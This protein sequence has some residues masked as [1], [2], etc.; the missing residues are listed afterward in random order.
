MSENINESSS[1]NDESEIVP[2]S[3]RTL[4]H[5]FR[6]SEDWWAVWI[7]GAI[8]GI[9]F[10]VMASSVPEDFSAQVEDAKISGEKVKLTSPL[11][12]W[13]AK[14]GKWEKN[15]LD[16]IYIPGEDGRNYLPGLL[17]VFCVSMVLFGLGTFVMKK[18]VTG[19]L[20]GFWFVF[21]LATFSY[22]LTG[23][24]VA[25]QYNLEYALWA[26]GI[27]LL[28]SNTVGTPAFV[29][30]ALLTE[31]YI[32]TGLVLLG[33]SVLFT[34]L[35][36]LGLPGICVAWVVTPIVLISTYLFGQ[37]VLKIESRSLNMVISADMSVCGVSAAIATA[38]ACKAKKEELSF[39]IGLSLS[40]TVLMM[41]LLPAVIKSLGLSPEMG[42]A[43]LG[44]TIDSTGAVAA[45]GGI[46]GERALE[47]AATIKMIQNI[48]I[49]VTAF[50]VAVYWVSVVEKGESNVRPDAWEIW[51]RFPKFVLGFIAASLVFTILHSSMEHGSYIVEGMVKTSTK[52]LRGWFF[53]LAFVSIGLDTNFRELAK[54]LKGGKPL[55][56]YVVGQSLNLILTFLMA[57]LMFEVVFKDSLQ[58]L[59]AM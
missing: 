50:G 59:G 57:W 33:A 31:F 14:P 49:G 34:K 9:A 3:P 27:G 20:K 38:A 56:L 32:K 13:L 8:L 19:F 28:I 26:L 12:A 29:K 7:G 1:D 24:V 46:L 52:T 48:L 23:Q 30:P 54:F 15:P 5:E 45:A 55:I 42:G 10:L 53:C 22:V 2:S 4:L 39:A 16:S 40:F 41:I 36:A 6:F 47:V 43:W 51:R 25:K 35:I 37:K 58:K 18:S 17:G 21:L 44:G 11:K